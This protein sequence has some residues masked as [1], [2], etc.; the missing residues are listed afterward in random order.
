MTEA[1]PLK[2]PACGHPLAKHQVDGLVVDVCRNGCGGVWFDNGEILEVDDREELAGRALETIE[3]RWAHAVNRKRKRVCPRCDGIWMVK[4]SFA[5][6]REVE[7]DECPGCG[8]LWLDAGELKAIRGTFKDC[9]ERRRVETALSKAMAARIDQASA[10]EKRRT[11]AF[12]AVAKFLGHLWHD[13][14]L[15][16]FRG[17]EWPPW[18]GTF[19]E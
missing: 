19:P 1:G 13:Y 11:Q 8:G 14:N 2:C 7:V 9:D 18:R 16:H 5:P 17:R 3:Q 6:G 12:H 4:H 15:L 10:P